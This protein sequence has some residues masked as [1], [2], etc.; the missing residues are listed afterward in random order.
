MTETELW[1]AAVD[2]VGGIQSAG[3]PAPTPTT[4]L[5]ATLRMYLAAWVDYEA[6]DPCW[7]CK[8]PWSSHDH[9]CLV[10]AGSKCLCSFYISDEQGAKFEELTGALTAILD[11]DEDGHP[12]EGAAGDLAQ[13]IRTVIEE[14]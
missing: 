12:W 11:E 14:A 6:T 4:E 1:R 5:Q 10:N 3:P 9:Q 7:R 13:V 2:L 8:H